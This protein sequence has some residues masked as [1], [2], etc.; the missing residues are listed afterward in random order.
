[1]GIITKVSA[2]EAPYKR[3]YNKYHV[4]ALNHCIQD[5]ASYPRFV[6]PDLD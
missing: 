6:V 2:L 3:K 5:G 4:L 1:M